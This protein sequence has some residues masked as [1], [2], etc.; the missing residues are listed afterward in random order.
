M[1][2]TGEQYAITLRSLPGW[3]VPPSKRLAQFLKAAKRAAGFT[4]VEVH[5]VANDEGAADGSDHPTESCAIQ[6][7]PSQGNGR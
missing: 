1:K 4:C 3:D 2:A 6:K 5:Q 7:A